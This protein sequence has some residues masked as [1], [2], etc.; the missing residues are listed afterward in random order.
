MGIRVKFLAGLTCALVAGGVATAQVS[1][2][3]PTAGVTVTSLAA[4]TNLPTTVSTIGSVVGVVRGSNGLVVP[5]YT[6]E[7]F[8]ADGNFVAD[9]VTNA[10]GRYTLASLP[11]GTYRVRV[12]GPRTGAAVWAMGWFGGSSFLNAKDLAVGGPTAKADVTLQRAAMVTGR[13]TGVPRGSE[14]RLCGESFLDCRSS[15]TDA[16]GNFAVRGLPAGTASVVV[17]PLR[18]TDLMFPEEPPRPGVTLRAS[19]ITRLELDAATQAAPVI[20]IGGKRLDTSPPPP[21]VDVSL[22][23]VISAVTS[24]ELGRRYVATKATDGLGGSGLA[25]VQ[26]RIGGVEQRATPYTSQPLLVPGD[27]EVSVRVTD[28]AGNS[29]DWVVAR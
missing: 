18:G 2:A 11:R 25:Q 14:V 9:T 24:E 13:V 12:S 15:L 6:V 20:M 4:A 17:R 26:L 7:A 27:G 1:S 3:Q 16:R 22:P 19:H 28:K 21:P 23:T 8:S 5:G 29:S 10:S